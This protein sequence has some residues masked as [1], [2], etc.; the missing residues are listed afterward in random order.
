MFTI[1]KLGPLFS[2]NLQWCFMQFWFYCSSVAI[3]VSE[4]DAP[5]AI[6]YNGAE[7]I[8]V[9]LN[10]LSWDCFSCRRQLYNGIC[11]GLW[12]MQ[13]NMETVSVFLLIMQFFS[14]VRTANQIPFTPNLIGVRAEI[15]QIEIAKFV[16]IKKIY[17]IRMARQCHWVR[18][19][20]PCCFFC[21]FGCS[22]YYIIMHYLTLLAGQ[23]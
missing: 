8:F 23:Y 9:L 5:S 16:Q 2:L 10:S 13:S 1:L 18:G 7:L 19:S 12:I 6:S 11:S 22:P 21:D 17:T 14:V 4:I 3:S 15:P 20:R